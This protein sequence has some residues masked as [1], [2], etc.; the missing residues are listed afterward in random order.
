MAVI[1]LYNNMSVIRHAQTSECNMVAIMAAKTGDSI[2][3]TRSLVGEIKYFSCNN[4]EI[5]E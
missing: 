1:S 2:E 3:S 4:L 5:V